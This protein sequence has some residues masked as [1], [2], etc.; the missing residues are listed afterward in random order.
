M[1]CIAEIAMTVFGVL[2]L[3]KGQFMLSRSK[4]VVGRPA[5]AIGLIL[6]LTFP[7]S[8]GIGFIVGFVM[9]LKLGRQPTAD[10]LLK[11]GGIDGIVV[12]LCLAT[13]LAVALAYG[14]P[15]QP[16]SS[17]FSPGGT[18]T[19]FPPADPNNPYSPPQSTNDPPN[20]R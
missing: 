13:S 10:E 18:M 5:Y 6:A 14:K 19:P 4:V 20:L 17:P 3:I 15:Q 2:T 16:K 11:L 8:M 7:I 1:C 12:L 9:V